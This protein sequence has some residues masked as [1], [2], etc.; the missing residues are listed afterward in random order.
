MLT[1]KNKFSLR[2]IIMLTL[3]LFL[4]F[5]AAYPAESVDMS[6]EIVRLHVIANSSEDTDQFI[7]LRVRD[8]VLKIAKDIPQNE[9]ESHLNLLEE[10]AKV[11]LASYGCNYSA[12]AIYGRFDFPAKS[13]GNVIFPAGEYSAVRI[14]LGDGVGK[15]WWCVMYPPLCFTSE[16]CGNFD[17]DA[18]CILSRNG[19]KPTF[20]IKVKLFEIFN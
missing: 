19:I 7:K 15:N 14:V 6:D 12:R 20:R 3:I 18:T 5:F 4:P 13:Y 2:K 16:T 11:V 10:G 8:E 1:L 9:I 17:E